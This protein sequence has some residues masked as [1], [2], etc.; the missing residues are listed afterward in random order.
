M[1]V[2]INGCFGGFGLSPAGEKAY[3][4]RKGKKAFF[5]TEDRDSAARPGDRDYIRVPENE[6]RSAF[7]FTTLTEDIGE[8]VAHNIIW[9]DGNAHQ[10]YFGK[11]DLERDDPDL[12]A[13]VE[14]D[15]KKY[16]GGF[17]SLQV[18]EIPDDVQWEIEEYDGLE[19]VAEAHRT[20]A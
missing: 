17:A 15:A 2:V 20:W 11:Y 5:Y 13:I 18:V 19:H 8:R 14:E 10:A 12:V 16:S 1:K 3:L 4:A 7:S 6:A 9:P